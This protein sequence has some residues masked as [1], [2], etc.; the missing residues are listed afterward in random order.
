MIVKFVSSEFVSFT[1]RDR[2]TNAR[3]MA[4]DA[5]WLATM[6]FN[7]EMRASYLE[8]KRHWNML[9]DEWDR[10]EAGEVKPPSRDAANSG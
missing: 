6:A 5:D 10:M 2:V 4:D 1:E 7:E 3:E 9:A 8:L